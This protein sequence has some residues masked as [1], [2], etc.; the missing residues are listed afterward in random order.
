MT[1]AF[2]FQLAALAGVTI[3]LTACTQRSAAVSGAELNNKPVDQNQAQ[4][5]A[6]VFRN[7]GCDMCHTFGRVVSGPDLAGIMDRRDREWLR[8]WLQQTST[9]LDGDPQAMDM[10]KQW[11]GFKMPEIKLMDSEVDALFH[12]FAQ[13]TAR[14]A[15][16]GK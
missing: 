14:A 7:K 10:L 6:T 1:H 12:Y 15:A 3:A 16:R 13:E 5:G 4:L 8:K 9:M 2:K 11:K